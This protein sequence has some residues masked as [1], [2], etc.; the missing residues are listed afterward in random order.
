MRKFSIIVPVYKVDTVLPRCI[1]SILNQ[2]VTDF[3]LILVDDGSPDRSGAICDEYAVRDS[4]IRV[5][6]QKNGGVSRARNAG[7]DIA[8]GQYIVFVDSD[9]WIDA[10]YLSG[11]TSTSADLVIGGYQIEGYGIHLPIVRQYKNRL[12]GELTHSEIIDHF[13]QGYLNYACTKAFA[14]SIIH[15]SHLRFDDTLNFAEDTLFVVQFIFHCSSVQ[16]IAAIGYHYV[17]YSH[18]TLTGGSHLCISAIEKIEIS[19]NIIHQTLVNYLGE[20]A[21]TAVVNRLMPLYKN[22]LCECLYES[23]C[24]WKY[25]HFLFRQT[26][27]LKVLN[28]VDHF[29][30]DENPKFRALLKTKSSTLFWLYLLFIRTKIALHR[31]NTHE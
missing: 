20:R 17:K 31:S 16:H 14:S 12:F 22:I 4:R 15:N 5:I 6:H 25:V 18:E 26:W 30:A 11:F 2:T 7:L 19:N 13:E 27:F 10:D 28:H 1:E 9:D 21:E 29:L 24:N 3:E 8:Q 23:A